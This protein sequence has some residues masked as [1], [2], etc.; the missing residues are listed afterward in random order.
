MTMTTI[1]NIFLLL[2]ISSPVIGVLVLVLIKSIQYNCPEEDIEGNPT[3]TFE[4]FL[5]HYNNAP[6]KWSWTYDYCDRRCLIYKS[7][8][9]YFTTRKDEK[10]FE[11]W[12]TALAKAKIKNNAKKR[13][14]ELQKKWASDANEAE[15]R[16]NKELSSLQKQYDEV[17]AA[18]KY[19]EDAFNEVVKGNIK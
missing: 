14:N 7:D 1:K 10:K 16:K 3:I 5:E 6:D 19:W 13:L 11:K 9:L 8:R 18:A 15:K 4:N 12:S 2:V 17:A